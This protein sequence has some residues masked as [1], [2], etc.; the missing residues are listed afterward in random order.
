[1]PPQILAV[2]IQENVSLSL[3]RLVETGMM[4]RRW[5]R[6]GCLGIPP[7]TTIVVPSVSSRDASVLLGLRVLLLRRLVCGSCSSSGDPACIKVPF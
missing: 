7:Q 6:Q 5:S 3:E 4:R 1:M 2:V